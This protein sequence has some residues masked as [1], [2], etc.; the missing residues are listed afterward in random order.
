MVWTP[1]EM[2]RWVNRV[3]YIRE[4]TVI[5]WGGP[6]WTRLSKKKLLEQGKQEISVKVIPVKGVPGGN[7]ASE[8]E[9]KNEKDDLTCDM[10][11]TVLYWH[12]ASFL[13]SCNQASRA[14]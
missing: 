1:D 10:A 5:G 7:K 13:P 14:S 11:T 12:N 2:G 6:G 3:E 4:R 8:L 9:I